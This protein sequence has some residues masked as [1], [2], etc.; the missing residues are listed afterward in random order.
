MGCRFKAYNFFLLRAPRLTSDILHEMNGFGSKAD[1]WNFIRE[2]LKDPQFLDAIYLAS[3]TLF[4]QVVARAEEDYTPEKDRLLIALYK[5]INRMSGRSTPLGK[6]AGVALGAVT[7]GSTQLQLS[8]KFG[9]CC[10]L[11]MEFVAYLHGLVLAE[12]TTHA[13]LFYYT[14]TTVY[15]TPERYHYIEFK[16]FGSNRSYSWAR[17]AKNP[18]L[19]QVLDCSRTGMKFSALV[20]HVS[21]LGIRSEGASRYIL[22]LI[23]AK[24]LISELES[25]TGNVDSK[26]LISRLKTGKKALFQPVWR[27]LSDSV[28][29]STVPRLDDLSYPAVREFRKIKQETTSHLVQVDLSLE[30]SSNK[31]GN[32]IMDTLST[33]LEELSVINNLKRPSE[34]ESFYQKFLIRYGQREVALLEV[35]DHERGVGYGSNPIYSTEHTPLLGDLGTR[36]KRSKQEKIRHAFQSVV[37]HHWNLNSGVT[38]H[39]ELERNDLEK[40]RSE[41]GEQEI[42]PSG[43]YALGNLFNDGNRESNDNFR[44]NLLSAGGVSAIPLMTRFCHLDP[45]LEAMLKEC[46]AWEESQRP[47]CVI[48]EIVYLPKGRA[49]NILARPNFFKYEIPIVGKGSVEDS[50]IISLDDLMVSVNN[51]KVIL[52]SKRLN[53]QVIPRLSSAHNF[54]HGM[55][56]YRFLCDLQS[57]YGALNLSWDWGELSNLPFTPRVSYKHIILSRARWRLPKVSNY[58]KGS[59]CNKIISH[60]KE[61]YS[62]PDIVSLSEGD[63][64]LV[65]DLR[66]PIGAEIVFKKLLKTEVVLQEYLW[67]E[68]NTVLKGSLGEPYSNE[69]IIPF[70]VIGDVKTDYL[71]PFFEFKIKRSFLPSSE[72]AF[73]KIY[74]GLVGAERLLQN[75]ISDLVTRLKKDGI[76]VKWFFIRYNDPDPHLRLRFL[77]SNTNDRMPFQTLANLINTYFDPLLQSRQVHRV[78]F[79]TY[80]RELE[81]YGEENMEVCESIFQVDSE[82]VLALLPLFKND[83]SHLRWLS[84]ML[85]VDHL[86][87]AFGLKIQEKLTLVTKLKNAFLNEFNGYSNL[88]YKLDRKYREHRSRIDPFFSEANDNPIHSILNR[89]LTAIKKLTTSVRSKIDGYSTSDLLPSLSHMFINR[90]FLAHPREHE[91]II[92]YLLAKQ[93]TSILNREKKRQLSISV[94]K[95]FKKA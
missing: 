31:I 90:L 62:I 34:L 84:G 15:E 64:E 8:G 13:D 3:D 40:L 19:K 61:R 29:N 11:D 56:V 59:D 21:A 91:M 65:I 93:Y 88:K 10:R 75:C 7:D 51:G 33:E 70:K 9:S 20:E 86:L 85:G 76:I 25:F 23:E 60:L 81:R 74:S 1:V 43:F 87:S 71:K 42:L 37:K 63:N 67:S 44:F 38:P 45:K 55:V 57:Q 52:R 39:I 30:M 5:Y 2:F 72:W 80:E 66:S 32:K 58:G 24:L 50:Y 16:D 94:T 47:D 54:H 53:K 6:F 22:E 82:S 48:A 35:I 28:D 12:E 18:L 4:E 49:G 83:D 78:V 41:I 27:S 77:L 79:D 17:V 89:R 36:K 26:L 73:I 14:N 95:S 69:I 46:A 68:Y 92:Y